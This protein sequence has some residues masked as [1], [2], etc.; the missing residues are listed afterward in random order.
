MRGADLVKPS[1]THGGET[2]RTQPPEGVA[3][4]S[5]GWSAAQPGA[6][7]RPSGAQP[8][9]GV[10]QPASAAPSGGWGTPRRRRPP[11]CAALHPGLDAVTPSG[12][13]L[14]VASL[15]SPGYA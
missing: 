2:I 14:I 12:G 11:G 9:E 10:T 13:W 7:V 15:P 5:P 1:A 4:S 6:R 3:A 8:P